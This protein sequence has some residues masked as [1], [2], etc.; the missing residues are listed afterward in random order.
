MANTNTMVLELDI[1]P[2]DTAVLDTSTL[3]SMKPQLSAFLI[4]NGVK[5]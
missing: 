2:E 1:V 3:Q 4:K 5:Q